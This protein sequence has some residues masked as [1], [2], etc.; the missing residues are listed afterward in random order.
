MKRVSN[1]W[2][3]KD[4]R[5]P[6]VGSF[7]EKFSNHWKVAALALIVLALG[8]EAALRW[9]PFPEHRFETWQASAVLT[10]RAGNPLRIW[11]G[12]DDL[13]CRPYYKPS[14]SDWIVQALIAAE[15]QRFW[16]HP[17]VDVLAILR[18][19]G[20]NASQGRVVSGASTLSTQVIRLVEPRSR[21]LW[22]KGIEAFRALQL[23]RR[24]DK[25]YILAQYLNRAPFGGNIVGIEAAAWRYFSKR[26]QDLS[27]A[28]AALLAG[29]PQSPSRG[30]PDRYPERA[31]Q[32][33][34]Y[35]L[36]RMEALGMITTDQHDVALAQ[37]LDVRSP[38]YPFTAPHFA[39][40]I[41][42]GVR[43]DGLAP[44]RTTLDA[45][46]QQLAED[47]LQRGLAGGRV[48]GGAIVILDTQSGAVR[49]MVGSPSFTGLPAGQV[50]AA[51]APR[52]AGSTLKPFAYA[53][54]MDSGWLTPMTVLSDVPTRFRDYEP[55]NFDPT[56]RGRVTARDAL[57]LSLNLPSIE[58]ARRVGQDRFHH[59]LQQLGLDTVSE[60]S[61]HYGIGLVLGNAEVR[62]LD[63]A[64]AYACLARGGEWR[65]VQ[66][67][68]DAP[69]ASGRRIF[70]EAACWMVAEMLSGAERAM[71]ATGH[72]ADTPLSRV[73]WKTGTS[74]GL[75]DAWTVA[76]NPE[77]V[78][79]VWIGN[80][81][82]SPADEL[83]G[84]QAATPLAWSVFRA[85]YPDNQGPWYVRPPDVV[86]RFVCAE[87][88]RPRRGG[89]GEGLVQDW[90]IAQVTRHTPMPT[91]LN[92]TTAPSRERTSGRLR[93]T[94][95]APES[96]YRLLAG[97]EAH[98]QQIPLTATAEPH[99]D[100]LFWFV[101]D[102]L[103]GQTRAGEPLIWP[104]ETGEH[105]IVCAN[106]QGQSDRIRITVE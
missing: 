83:V 93:I 11:L 54:G 48:G 41:G 35:V 4:H 47:T 101:N 100:L 32:R 24:H 81:D 22:T 88:G 105:L 40:W 2:K 57:V 94:V 78:V 27:L 29:V 9:V 37:R 1:R 20:Q 69:R 87:T 59:T 5:F 56:F 30:R 85:L 31:K 52:A 12:P 97:M 86:S 77:Y 65:P 98:V 44:V 6:I 75:R 103:M 102:R 51:L 73:A 53:L 21:T 66:Y 23:E 49:A 64:N 67:V 84:R 79:G 45:K 58:V 82:G 8:V 14:A 46:L 7:F 15:D 43:A 13:D 34:T 71:D 17:G 26:P 104:L 10:D 74:A 3:E 39:D 38:R 50:N 19:V 60:P 72:T 76:Y 25:M 16:S 36:Q 95:P 96:T 63:L 18:A 91:R 80:P 55:R 28:E 99:G 61:A 92:L 106:T 33:L 70:S 90:A 68:Q 42:A 62:L 89:E